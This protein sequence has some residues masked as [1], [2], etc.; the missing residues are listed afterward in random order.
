[1]NKPNLILASGSRIRARL[2]SAA[3]IVFEARAS[4]VNER[5]IKQR[6]L[7]AGCDL[8]RIALDLAEA[9]AR[10]V[11]AAADDFVIGADQILEFENAPFDKPS[12]MD[13]ARERLL[14]MAGQT[15]SLINA[16]VIVRDGALVYSHLARPRLRLRPLTTREIDQYIAEAGPEILSSVGAYQVEALGQRLFDGIE[17]EY[18]AVLGLSMPPLLAFLRSAGL[19]D[20]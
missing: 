1:M 9:K 3:G 13:E 19:I 15:H 20:Y 6:A 2:L 11:R 12:S 14:H 18:T 7:D 8:E 17:G 4:D 5:A 10:A 16:T